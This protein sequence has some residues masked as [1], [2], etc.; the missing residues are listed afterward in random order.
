MR[1]LA[2]YQQTEVM[3]HLEKHLRSAPLSIE[4]VTIGDIFF[5]KAGK[6]KIKSEVVDF[7]KAYSLSTGETIEIKVVVKI[8]GFSSANTWE[9]T[10]KDV[11]ENGTK[12]PKQIQ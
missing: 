2:E 9:T 4:G 12:A 8:H 6:S 1:N 3:S 5:T 11:L 10:F 7:V